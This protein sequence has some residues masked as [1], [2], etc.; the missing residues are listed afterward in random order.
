VL[1]SRLLEPLLR[2]KREREL[3]E[4]IE[5][6]LGFL[7]EEHLRRVSTPWPPALRHE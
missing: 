5:A 7:T 2:R 6:H 4:E 1:L 3:A